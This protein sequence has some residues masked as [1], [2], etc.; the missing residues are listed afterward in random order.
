MAYFILT[1]GVGTD[2]AQFITTQFRDY[3]KAKNA[4]HFLFDLYQEDLEKGKVKSF[5]CILKTKGVVNGKQKEKHKEEKHKEEN[6][7]AK[8][9]IFV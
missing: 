8:W 3:K 1:H 9:G 6:Y 4:L 7:H 2:P 5:T